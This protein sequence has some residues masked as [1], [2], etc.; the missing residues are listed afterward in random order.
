MA[1]NSA[2]KANQISQLSASP[3]VCSCSLTLVN[4]KIVVGMLRTAAAQA[5]SGPATIMETL[6]AVKLRQERSETAMS[7]ALLNRHR[8]T[9]KQRKNLPKSLQSTRYRQRP[10]PGC[11]GK[12][13][14]PAR[15]EKHV[16]PAFLGSKWNS[17]TSLDIGRKLVK[18]GNW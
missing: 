16:L 17:S 5:A 9:I 2:K 8:R 3:S 12:S 1:T 18:R 15:L 10:G 11:C 7:R 14:A 6:K 13:K 4:C